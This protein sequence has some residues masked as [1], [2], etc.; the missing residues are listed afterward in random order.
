MSKGAVIIK[1]KF[2]ILALLSFIIALAIFVFTFNLYHHLG[3][4]G[5]FEAAFHAVPEKPFITLLFGIWGVCF[6]F[7]SVFSLLVGEIF[8]R[9]K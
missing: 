8:F 6:L 1:K 9:K 7:A 5:T 4:N 3:S 2:R